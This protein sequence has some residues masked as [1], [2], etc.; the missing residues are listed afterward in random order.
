MHL[1]GKT[2]DEV[3]STFRWEVPPRFNIGARDLRRPCRA[4]A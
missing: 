1:A 3:Y 2:Y 4:H